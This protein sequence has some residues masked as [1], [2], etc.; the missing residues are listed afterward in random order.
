MNKLKTW[1]RFFL[2]LFFSICNG[3]FFNYLNNSFF[4]LHNDLFEGLSS[5]E[6]A[7]LSV[8]VAPIIETILFQFL[9]YKMLKT[10]LSIRNDAICI[11]I[12][13]IIFSQLHWYHWLYVLMTFTGGMIL[14]IYYV[15]SLKQSRYSLILTILLH[16]T[17]NL[18]G[19]LFVK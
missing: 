12:M 3:Y 15:S 9:L 19:V 16:S 8:L 11:I 1:K 7:F 4:Q 14:N 10:S 18:Y 6:L 13:S 5:F 17:Y 2:F